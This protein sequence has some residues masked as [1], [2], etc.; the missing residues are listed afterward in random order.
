MNTFKA[1]VTSVLLLLLIA[2]CTPSNATYTV[3]PDIPFPLSEP[4]PYFPGY[5]ETTIIDES[6]GG[7][8]IGI[9]VWYPAKEETNPLTMEGAQPNRGDAPFPLILTGA[10]T[11]SELFDT[12]LVTHGFVMVI[13]NYPD[14]YP[15]YDVGVIDHPRDMLFVLDQ[16]ASQPPQDLENLLDTENVGVAGYSWEGLYSLMVSGARIDPDYY[17]TQCAEAQ[18]GDPAPEEWWIDWICN[19]ADNW[20]A[21][22]VNAG[23]QMTNSSDGLWQP[24][25]DARIQAVMPMGPEGAWLFGERGLAAV[26]RPTMILAGTED[27][28]NYYD[29]EAVYIFENLGV[30]DRSMVSFIDQ[31][32]SM[33]DVPEQA[34]RMNHFVTAFFGYHLQGREDFAEYYSEEYVS[35]QEGLAWGVY[36]K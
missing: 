30:P 19:A 34:K 36:K 28:I 15:N 10:T 22:A 27:N 21:F 18:P 2:A 31:T 26:D 1:L 5:I 32:H 12:H 17:L 13:V 14:E 3:A 25:T 8:E 11:G 35:Q 20:D 29:L 6:R 33:A 9:E 23:S 4:G 16:I 24:L 7:R